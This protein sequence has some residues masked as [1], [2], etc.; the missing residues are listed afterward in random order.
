MPSPTGRVDTEGSPDHSEC[1]WEAHFL[2]CKDSSLW[3]VCDSCGVWRG[4]DQLCSALGSLSLHSAFWPLP[5][6]CQCSEAGFQSQI[7][8]HKCPRIARELVV[9]HVRP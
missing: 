1:P 9:P 3:S 6:Q 2:Y 8:T 4:Q 7:C 5:S